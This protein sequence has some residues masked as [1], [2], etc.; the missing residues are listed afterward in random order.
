[1]IGGEGGVGVEVGGE[2][3]EASS[4]ADQ[5]VE[6]SNKLRQIRNFNLLGDGGTQESSNTSCASHMGQ[7]LGEGAEETDGAGDTSGDTN[8][9]QGITEPGSWL[10]RQT[11][12]GTN[13]A[14]TRGKVT[15]LVDLWVAISYSVPV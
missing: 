12:Q 5:G 7:H 8:H 10:G 3:G 11:T 6:G 14:Q 1:M 15:H 9:T 4:H 2:A 13:T